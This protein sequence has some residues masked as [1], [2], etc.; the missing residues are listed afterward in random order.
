VGRRQLGI[1]A[2]RFLTMFQGVARSIY[3]QQQ[4][5]QIAVRQPQLGIQLDRTLKVHLRLL[6]VAEHAAGVAEVIVCQGELGPVLQRLTEKG[7]CLDGAASLHIQQAK[8]ICRVRI[9]GLQSQRQL[10]TPRGTIHISQRA[11][12]FA[13]IGLKGGAIGL[14]GRGAFQPFDGLA[15]LPQLQISYAKELNRL[16]MVGIGGRNLMVK[17][18]GLRE[19]AALVVDQSR[20]EANPGG[21][22]HGDFSKANSRAERLA[23]KGVQEFH[24]QIVA[25]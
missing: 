10:K 2:N 6:E 23:Q 8:I 12:G 20:G 13:Q 5:P 4:L 1:E 17:L 16:R 18:N 11:I 15:W 19:F 25:A 14:Q 24:T 21:V 3:F 9:V 7:G 22:R